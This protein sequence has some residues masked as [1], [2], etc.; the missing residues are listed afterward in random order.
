MPKERPSSKNAEVLS[1]LRK[2]G[3]VLT[4]VREINH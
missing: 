4:Q 2:H 1:V 3:D